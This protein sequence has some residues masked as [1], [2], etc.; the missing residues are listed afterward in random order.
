MSRIFGPMPLVASDIFAGTI[1]LSAYQAR[2]RQAR[3]C[4]CCFATLRLSARAASPVLFSCRIWPRKL[5]KVSAQGG[6]RRQNERKLRRGR[7]EGSGKGSIKER[8]AGLCSRCRDLHS[9][10]M[11]STFKPRPLNSL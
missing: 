11:R 9:I 1:F 2:H 5:A 8:A 4:F 10:S 7:R 6:G 3:L